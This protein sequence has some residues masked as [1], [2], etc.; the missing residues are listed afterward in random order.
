MTGR[1][2]PHA[3]VTWARI[4]F[5]AQAIAGTAW[6]LLV[7][8][9]EDVRRWTLGAWDPAWLV[10]PDLLLFVGGSAATALTGRRG[11]ALATGAWTFGITVLLSTYGLLERTAGWG[12]VAMSVATFA[13]CAAAATVWR[14]RLPTGWFFVGPFSFRP[15][16]DRPEGRHVARSLAQLVVFWTVFFL[17]VP[18]IADAV[19]HRLRIEWPALDHRIATGAGIVLFAVGSA[20]GLWSCLTMA[21]RGRGTPLPADTARELVVA[22]PYRVIRN[23]MATAGA[24]QTVGVGLWLGSWV[25]VAL[26]VAGAAAW[27]VV[28]RPVEEEDLAER[29]GPPYEAYRHQVRCWVPVRPTRGQPAP[30]SVSP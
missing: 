15:A 8:A 24:V 5:A 1:V 16:P 18:L 7:V 12:V 19:E 20:V 30:A 26:A 4:Y 29:F 10:G 25:V 11:A 13:T 2:T 21:V 28:I 23:P 17:V 6:W 14:G 27:H 22:G 9:S 3:P